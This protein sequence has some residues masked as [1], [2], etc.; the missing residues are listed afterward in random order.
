MGPQG[1]RHLSSGLEVLSHT[2]GAQTR[3]LYEVCCLATVPELRELLAKTPAAR[4]LEEGNERTMQ[5]ILTTV[6]DTSSSL[7][8]LE[9]GDNF[10]IT[11]WV[12]QGKGWLFLPYTAEQIPALKPLF[13]TWVRTAIFSALSLP[14]RDNGLWFVAMSRR[15]GEDGRPK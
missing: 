15:S 13:R 9:R 3:D 4:F 11:D 1:A 5:S 7:R 12:R 6:T 2:P 10:S 8:Y 14:E